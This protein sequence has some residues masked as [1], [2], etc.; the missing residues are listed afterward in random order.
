M[1]EED[2]TKPTPEDV[3]KAKE[4]VEDLIELDQKRTKSLKE[5]LKLEREH[6]EHAIKLL[7]MEASEREKQYEREIEEA[8]KMA[9][10][11]EA[12]DREKIRSKSRIF[13]KTKRS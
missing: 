13:K 6:A 8:E 12:V 9:A 1:A 2:D 7:E 5:R 4:A 10:R 3:K 11:S